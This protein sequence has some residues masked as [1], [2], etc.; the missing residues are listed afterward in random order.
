MFARTSGSII[1][2]RQFTGFL[3][4]IGKCLWLT[5]LSTCVLCLDTKI[6]TQKR[7]RTTWSIVH[8]S[9]ISLNFL[10]IK[11]F[12]FC[13]KVFTNFSKLTCKKRSKKI[14]RFVKSSR[15]LKQ[16]IDAQKM[17]TLKKLDIFIGGGGNL[18]FLC[19]CI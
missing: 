14:P 3:I 17:R 9:L 10:D 16:Q 12:W 15:I 8:M 19:V 18:L 2:L 4:K 5:V 13:T 7:N 11:I 1:S 6:L